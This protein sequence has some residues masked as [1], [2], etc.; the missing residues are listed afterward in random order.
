MASALSGSIHSIR[1]SKPM[2][3]L[4]DE[5]ALAFSMDDRGRN[6]TLRSYRGSSVLAKVN[7]EGL[8]TAGKCQL[9]NADREAHC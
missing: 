8:P 3:S 6:Q 9:I 2:D 4:K 5:T 7:G 1:T